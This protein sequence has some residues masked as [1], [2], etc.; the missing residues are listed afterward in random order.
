MRESMRLA[1]EQTR[2]AQQR[3]GAGNGGSREEGN[4]GGSNAEGQKRRKSSVGKW[5]KEKLGFARKDSAA[6]TADG[7]EGQGALPGEREGGDEASRDRAPSQASSMLGSIAP[8]VAPIADTATAEEVEMESDQPSNH[9]RDHGPTTSQSHHPLIN[10]ETGVERPPCIGCASPAAQMPLITSA[11][12]S[13]RRVTF[14]TD[15][16]D[17]PIDPLDQSN[18]YRY[19]QEEPP[20]LFPRPTPTRTDDGEASQAP[21]SGVARSEIPQIRQE[22]SVGPFELDGTAIGRSI[23]TSA[24]SVQGSGARDRRPNA[25]ENL[26]AAADDEGV[27]P[28]RREEEEEEG[29]NGGEEEEGVSP[30]TM[31]GRVL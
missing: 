30:T 14:A 23:E 31:A 16:R 9:L 7:E 6:Q 24:S 5:L 13:P 8:A 26:E 25:Q 18:V 22:I 1:R 29:E 11:A 12:E 10:D 19:H 4:Q 17:Q 28:E 27:R 15:P 21:T 3:D 2:P 20:T